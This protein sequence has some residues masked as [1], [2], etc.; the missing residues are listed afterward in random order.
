MSEQGMPREKEQAFT[1]K[2]ADPVEKPKKKKCS[3][4]KSEKKNQ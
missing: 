4:Q 1:R 2:Q 3:S